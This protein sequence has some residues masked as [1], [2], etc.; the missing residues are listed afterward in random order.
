MSAGQMGHFHGIVAVQKYCF[1]SPQFEALLPVSCLVTNLQE[2]SAARGSSNLS[3]LL[4]APCLEPPS[5]M[6]SAVAGPLSL[7]LSREPVAVLPE[8]KQECRGRI[9]SWSF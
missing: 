8:C 3:D 7:K 4:K 6:A 5:Y 2:P 1:L 9:L